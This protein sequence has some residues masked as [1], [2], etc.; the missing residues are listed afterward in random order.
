MLYREA[1]L[2]VMPV[3]WNEPVGI[4]G[5]GAMAHGK[6]VVA[7][8]TEGIR[9][10]LVP[11]ETGVLVP[12]GEGAVFRNEVCALLADAPRLQAMARRAREVWSERFRPER[13]IAALVEHYEKLREMKI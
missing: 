6:P 4:E 9:D 3:R 7:F 5:L 13:H 12:F 8:D 1:T 11:G 2:V 10:W